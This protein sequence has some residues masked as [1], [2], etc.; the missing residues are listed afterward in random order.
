MTLTPLQTFVI[1]CM[2]TLGTVITRFLPFIV[3]PDNRKRHPYITYLGKVLPYAVIGLLV[4]YCLK[5][6]GFAASSLW[7]PEA[8]AIVCIVML[9]CWKDNVLVSIGAGTAIYMILVQFVF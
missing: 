5:D 1:I 7:L 8:V 3:F 6:V 4:A 2:V 9:H